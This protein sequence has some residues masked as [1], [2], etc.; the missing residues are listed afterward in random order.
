[1]AGRILL[2]GV[3][4]ALERTVHDA[5]HDVESFVWVLS[6]AVMR[7]LYHRASERST[8]K[9]VRDERPTFRYLFSQAFGQTTPRAIAA[10]RQSASYCLTF[11]RDRAVNKIVSSFMSD[12]LVSF[13]RD[14][15]GLIHHA[16]DPFNPSLLAHDTLLVVVNKTI[17]SLL[18]H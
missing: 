9:E 4:N 12:A 1:M 14:L 17:N 11:P 10:Q 15:Q 6:Y 18:A 5:T 2:Q 3:D 7:N 8:P 16:T 13:F